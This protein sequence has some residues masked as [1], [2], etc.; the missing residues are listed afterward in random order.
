ML[1]NKK[2]LLGM[3]AIL[4]LF[5]LPNVVKA[6]NSN[7]TIKTE[8]D[9][10]NKSIKVTLSN[11]ELD[12]EQK[13]Y[14]FGVSNARATEPTEWLPLQE[15]EANTCTLVITPEKDKMRT[16]LRS[17]NKCYLFIKEKDSGNKVIT[18]QVDLSLPLENALDITKVDNN[19]EITYLYKNS[20]MTGDPGTYYMTAIKIDDTNIIKKYLEAKNANKNT[21]NEIKDLIDTN[22]PKTS[23]QKMTSYVTFSSASISIN[24]LIKYEGLYIVWGQVSYEE[25]R[26]IYGYTL[27]DNYP[28]G[29]K[30]PEESKEKVDTTTYISFPFIIMNGKGS[31]NLKSGVYD[32]SYTMYY[33]FVEVND[34]VMN[35]LTE[36]QNKYKKGDITYEEYFTKYKNTVTK[37]NDTNW[38]KT[39]DGS[40]KIDLN[41]FTGTKKFALW[42][43]LEMKDK[44][45]YETQIYTMDGSGKATNI[46]E[47]QDKTP[48]TTETQGTT[49]KKDT[50]TATS[51]LPNTGRV[52]LAWIIGIVTVSAIVAHIRYKKLYIK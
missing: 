4:L 43:K 39:E 29:Y 51:K 19:F 48:T 3:L 5:I 38:T 9:G 17:N 52:I 16:I 11:I 1:K 27:Y 46:P 41:K 50:T 42:V 8:V 24:S 25:G 40:F 20:S 34:S 26:S 22:I 15:V 47:A 2:I 7:P 35:S 10:A 21:L 28:N 23:W 36:L 12:D 32:G 30:L 37:Y 31:V 14:E 33:Q 44:T 45:V 49:Q 6:D 18:T 13:Q